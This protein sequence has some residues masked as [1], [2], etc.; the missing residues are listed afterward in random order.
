LEFFEFQIE[1][2]KTTSRVKKT[3]NWNNFSWQLEERFKNKQRLKI[4]KYS[5][6]FFFVQVFGSSRNVVGGGTSF[7][8][9]QATVE[10]QT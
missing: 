9:G 7:E 5:N 3:I 4:L 10:A 1:R 2:A 8:C 6:L